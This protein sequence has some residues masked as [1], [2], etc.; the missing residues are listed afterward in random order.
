VD[1][2]TLLACDD[3]GVFRGR[4]VDREIAHT[5]AGVRHLAIAVLL[6]NARGEVLLQKRKHRLFDGLWD[7]SG[8]THPLH[9]GD[10]PDE[11]P[12]E[13]T[14]RCL[15]REYGLSGL[16]AEEIGAFNYYAQDAERCENEHCLLFI[17]QYD[18]EV[19]VSDE[20]AYDCQ[21]V[22]LAALFLGVAQ[23]PARYTPWAIESV[24]LLRASEIARKA[25]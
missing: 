17:A 13:A 22:P 8:A 2:Q 19:K 11:T 9:R 23:H 18:G 14:A 24:P 25:S 12:E 7:V 5:G 21:W 3:G 15:E 1:S 6:W 4:Y 16:L 20:V 10:Q